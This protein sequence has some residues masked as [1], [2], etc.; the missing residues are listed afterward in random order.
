MGPTKISAVKPLQ[1]AYPP[2]KAILCALSLFAGQVNANDDKAVLI[3]AMKD[4]RLNH[5][6]FKHN[7]KIHSNDEPISNMKQVG[8]GHK[9]VDVSTWPTVPSLILTAYKDAI[10]GWNLNIEP[11]HFEFAPDQVNTSNVIGKGHA[12][13][14]INGEKITRLYSRWYYLENLQQGSSVVSVALNANDHGPLVLNGQAVSA[15][16]KLIQE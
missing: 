13:L 3:E 11:T 15:S 8:L 7:G 1:F 5:A 12:H 4:N 9:P 6:E 14:Y 16:I 10:A 2:T